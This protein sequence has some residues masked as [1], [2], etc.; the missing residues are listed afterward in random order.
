MSYIAK[1]VS[2]ILAIILAFCLIVPGMYVL[3][4]N[5]AFGGNN[6]TPPIANI[7]EST[8]HSQSTD[9]NDKNAEE[10]KD[11]EDNKASEENKDGEDNKEKVTYTATFD[12]NG[13]KFD[14]NAEIVTYSKEVT[15]DEANFSEEAE[16]IPTKEGYTFLGWVKDGKN[17]KEGKN[18]YTYVVA[19][20]FK[21]GENE[22]DLTYVAIWTQYDQC[23]LTFN[24]IGGEFVDGKF[25]LFGEGEN[26]GIFANKESTQ[27]FTQTLNLAT[28]GYYSFKVE[29]NTIS[30]N[31][32]PTKEGYEF[33]GWAKE[34]GN[35]VT[36]RVSAIR[37]AFTYYAVWE[38]IQ[39]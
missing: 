27:T 32:V 26:N 21:V 8:G 31:S 24:A 13:G 35:D 5:G 14:K 1:T 37:E 36:F 28:N 18:G 23:T 15:A 12:A 10:N 6:S 11:N 29:K 25:V 39:A 9:N 16:I 20:S 4:R 19:R 17:I 33:K 38:K 22:K 34:N 30:G 7:E 2:C 3:S